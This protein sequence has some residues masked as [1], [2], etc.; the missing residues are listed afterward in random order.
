[1]DEIERKK[2]TRIKF[3]IDF[4]FILSFILFVIII[5]RYVYYAC[6]VLD[7]CSINYVVFFIVLSIVVL[8]IIAM[9]R[10]KRDKISYFIATLKKKKK[11]K[12]ETQEKLKHDYSIEFQREIN[13]IQDIKYRRKELSRAELHEE[14]YSSLKNILAAFF[15][16]ENSITTKELLYIIQNSSLEQEFKDSVIDFLESMRNDFYSKNLHKKKQL[17]SDLEKLNMFAQK[18][19]EFQQRK[20]VKN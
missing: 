14:I 10:I 8:S 9:V 2:Y 16:K 12:Q 15:S 11:E 3:T 6:I 17:Y 20:R 18:L 7:M 5:V 4:L 13:N 1:M 19:N